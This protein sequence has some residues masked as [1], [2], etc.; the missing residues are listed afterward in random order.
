MV[1]TYAGSGAAFAG[2]IG[3]C[4]YDA[5]AAQSVLESFAARL[6]TSLLAQFSAEPLVRSAERANQTVAR[7]APESS[8]TAGFARLAEKLHSLEPS[9]LPLPK[10]LDDAALDL[11]LQDGSGPRDAPTARKSVRPA[12]AG[13]PVPQAPLP[14]RSSSRPK[15]ARK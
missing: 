10:P 5:Q 6:G 7:F 11:F 12:P 14:Q 1:C 2:L 9:A 8:V 3:N 4:R 13:L 15:R